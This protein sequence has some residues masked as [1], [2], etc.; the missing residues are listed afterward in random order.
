[1]SSVAFFTGLLSLIAA[2]MFDTC[3]LTSLFLAPGTLQSM[4]PKT[5]TESALQLFEDAFDVFCHT[6]KKV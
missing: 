3:P 5:Y 4:S 6:T 2:I 1:M